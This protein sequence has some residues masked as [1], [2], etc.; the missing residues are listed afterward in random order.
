MPVRR[1][2][3]TCSLC[4][5]TAHLCVRDCRAVCRLVRRCMRANT[6]SLSPT[7][8]PQMR[9][10]TYTLAVLSRCVIICAHVFGA[11]WARYSSTG[12][13]GCL[14]PVVYG[15]KRR[16]A[17]VSTT[18]RRAGG[19]TAGRRPVH[20]HRPPPELSLCDMPVPARVR[21]RP[22]LIHACPCPSGASCMRM[23]PSRSSRTAHAFGACHHE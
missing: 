23:F 14:P 10:L 1:C 12:L 2:Q 13:W 11:S 22:I 18:A 3:Y 6:D 19:R 9:V 7:C 5:L 15:R 20:W 16:P 4:R 17:R 21:L 8:S